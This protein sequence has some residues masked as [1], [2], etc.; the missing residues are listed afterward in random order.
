MGERGGETAVGELHDWPTRR[1]PDGDRAGV[2]VRGV[3]GEGAARGG[4]VTDTGEDLAGGGDAVGG[5]PVE[6]S[7]HGGARLVGGLGVDGLLLDHGGLLDVDD[8]QRTAGVAS[9]PGRSV[10]YG[11][12]P[13]MCAY[14]DDDG[15]RIAC[16][17]RAADGGE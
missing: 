7:G 10:H 13:V 17:G 5:E 14:G 6:M 8:L 11:G 9:H 12:G 1:V 3:P 2:C 4:V 16:G 15:R